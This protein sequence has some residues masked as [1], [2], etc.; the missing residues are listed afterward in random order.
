MQ[1]CLLLHNALV[2][3]D[4]SGFSLIFSCLKINKCSSFKHFEVHAYSIN[5]KLF[6]DVMAC[7]KS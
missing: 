1:P 6:L 3:L 5:F 2:F 4:K 7:Q